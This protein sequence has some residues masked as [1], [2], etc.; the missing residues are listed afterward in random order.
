MSGPGP[1][2]YAGVA[3]VLATGVRG[4]ADSALGLREP[5][6]AC[7]LATAAVAWRFGRGPGL[8]C[9][10][11]GFLL[12]DWFFVAPRGSLGIGDMGSLAATA[13]YAAVSLVVVALCH[14]RD[15]DRAWRRNEGT[16]SAVLESSV[17]PIVV[18]DAQGHIEEFSPAAERLFVIPRAA[19]LGRPLPELAIA[20][21]HRPLYQA[22]LAEHRAGPTPVSLIEVSAHRADGA[23]LAVAMTI[24]RM[25]VGGPPRF[26]AC[27]HD[28]TERREVEAAFREQEALLGATLDV[29]VDPVVYVERS[30][31]VRVANAAALYLL[32]DPLIGI[33]P[34][35][36]IAQLPVD[37]LGGPGTL[38]TL[39]KALESGRTVRNRRV[40]LV[41][42]SGSPRVVL[43]SIV[44]VVHA[45]VVKGAV[46]YMHDVTQEHKLAAELERASVELRTRF[47]EL[48]AQ[49]E[50]L[51][52][53]SEE[54]AKQR[55][56]LAD[57]NADLTSASRLK[58]EVLATMSHE[59]RTPLNAVI[60][61]AEVLLADQ[62]FPLGAA[63]RPLITDIRGAGEQL[64]LLI[65]DVLDLT[66]I[67][68]GRLQLRTER[69]DLA[70]PM[71]QARELTSASAQE[72]ALTV[73]TEIE[74]GQI[75]CVADPDRVRQIM[76][77][78]LSNAIKFTPS[79]G[80][81]TL[82][83]LELRGGIVRASVTDTGVGIDPNDLHKLFQPFT[84]LDSGLARRH[85]GSGLGLAISKQ[86][87]EAMSGT[88]GCESAHGRGSTFF[89]TL[90]LA[91]AAGLSKVGVSEA[92]MGPMGSTAPQA[93]PR[94]SVGVAGAERALP[95]P[96][97]A[98]E[99]FPTVRAPAPA[100]AA[101]ARL[102]VL[103]VDDNA[104]N[105]RV[106]RAMLSPL[107]CDLT[108]AADGATAIQLA[109]D[110]QPGVI[111]MDIQMPEMD[112]LAATS[113]LAADPATADI[114]V[115]AITAHAMLAD[116]DRAVAAGCVGYLP[117]PVGRESLMHAIDRAIG[118][119][120][121]R[122]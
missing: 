51:A 122:D 87:A 4:L 59:L 54:V 86:L 57:R 115:I 40:D 75:F 85:G 97:P 72:R 36:W 2:L 32:G 29:L 119:R 55:A 23:P 9:A 102:H 88:I 73:V 76:L 35:A 11:V 94:P 108:E 71:L 83:A 25:L 109:R 84:Q 26:I 56:L 13:I 61:F 47:E 92:T 44:P 43:A 96:E 17:D 45:G 66:R 41:D 114:P 8:F 19:A 78:F 77:N 104:V 112:G 20:P 74:P 12:A 117:K 39:R 16:W 27:I 3:A 46:V 6:S 63:H 37:F 121:W 69:I 33:T 106:L 95:F 113:I 91:N 93:E 30:G 70:L 5:F 28:L 60:G 116:A 99:P 50:V 53:Q 98:L 65:N 107:A 89:F 67:E 21:E 1:Y 38:D 79:G 120:A 24:R 68:A 52:A 18:V 14:R 105:R 80:T 15:G 48:L 100:L 103:I 49:Q 31:L 110:L 10:S 90:P 58:S 42:A 64:L 62:A 118:S 111:L 81:V 34:D 22:V 7:L 82:R 101:G